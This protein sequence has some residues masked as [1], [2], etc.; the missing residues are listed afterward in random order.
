MAKHKKQVKK[1]TSANKDLA[2]QVAALHDELAAT[3]AD[4]A[5]VRAELAKAQV[6]IAK[7]KGRA[8]AASTPEPAD[9]DR[10]ASA[11]P[12]AP[13]VT[14]EATDVAG[15]PAGESTPGAG[16]DRHVAAASDDE[17]GPHWTVTRLREEIKRRRLT[18]HSRSTKDQL[19]A[20]LAGL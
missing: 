7:W 18:G 15:E 2:K 19:L 17:P 3:H 9:A 5:T 10:S 16:A 14:P 12:E 20:A 8:A 13:A 11:V 6:K 4:L 1:L